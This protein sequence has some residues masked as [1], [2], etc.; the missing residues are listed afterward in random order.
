M[1]LVLVVVVVLPRILV[2]KLDS[3]IFCGLASFPGYLYTQTYT[4]YKHP[5]KLWANLLKA[6][7][8]SE[9]LK[10][11]R[12]VLLIFGTLIMSKF[13]RFICWQR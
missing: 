3:N 8:V 10:K 2:G 9:S 12:A 7:I 1:L 5:S 4:K 13:Y 6:A 11:D